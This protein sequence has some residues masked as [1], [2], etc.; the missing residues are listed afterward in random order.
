MG[1]VEKAEKH[2]RQMRDAVS[3][4]YWAISFGEALELPMD[5]TSS[6]GLIGFGST[7]TALIFTTAF[8]RLSAVHAIDS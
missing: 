3:D 7:E 6:T 4:I 8:S 1:E 5:V 2:A